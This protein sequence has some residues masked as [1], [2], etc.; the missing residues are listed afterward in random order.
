MVAEQ[1]KQTDQIPTV[2]I[3]GDPA[4]GAN[5]VRKLLFSKRAQIAPAV[6][7]QDQDIYKKFGTYDKELDKFIQTPTVTNQGLQMVSLEE[8]VDRIDSAHQEDSLAIS[9]NISERNKELQQV[10]QNLRDLRDRIGGRGRNRFYQAGDLILI[11]G[12]VQVRLYRLKTQGNLSWIGEMASWVIKPSKVH[13]LEE[14]AERRVSLY[15]ERMTEQMEQKSLLDN[16]YLKEKGGTKLK[17]ISVQEALM[18]GLDGLVSTSMDLLLVHM[19]YY[20]RL[21]AVDQYARVHGLAGGARRSFLRELVEAGAV[22]VDS[23]KFLFSVGY[24]AAVLAKSELT[25]P[26]AQPSKTINSGEQEGHQLP[27][28]LIINGH[29]FDDIDLAK[30]AFDELEKGLDNKTRRAMFRKT[31]QVSKAL[32]QGHQ[33]A[34]FTRIRAADLIDRMGGEWHI[35]VTRHRIILNKVYSPDR[36][37]GLEIVR[38]VRNAHDSPDYY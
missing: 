15:K 21:S 38:I 2:G 28:K 19:F 12:R 7:Y 9:Q 11:L 29:V 1:A 3:T 18:E 6:F 5:Y 14:A 26:T 35:K 30:A 8:E 16:E 27:L 36:E 33:P 32:S 4:A 25:A 31:L 23:Y 20:G 13:P 10:E 17:L 24:Q 34:E 37:L 22:S